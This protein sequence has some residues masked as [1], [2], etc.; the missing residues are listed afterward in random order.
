[1][2]GYDMASRAPTSKQFL[3]I[4]LAVI[5]LGLEYWAYKLSGSLTSQLS[6]AIT[7]SDTD[8]VIMYYIGGVISF[9]VGIFLLS[10]K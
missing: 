2:K 8:E 1:M 5:G 9:V 3:G 10:R 7:G 4:A 6:T